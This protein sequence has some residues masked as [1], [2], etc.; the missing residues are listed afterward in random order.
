MASWKPTA[1][2]AHCRPRSARRPRVG[3][4]SDSFKLAKG[5]S[6]PPT[7]RQAT[8]P[9]SGVKIEAEGALLSATDGGPGDAPTRTRHRP[10]RGESPPS[11]PQR[12]A[13][14]QRWPPTSGG[15]PN[16]RDS[17]GFRLAVPP[18]SSTTSPPRPS[19]SSRWPRR[20]G[21]RRRRHDSRRRPP[22]VP[23]EI[24]PAAPTSRRPLHPPQTRS[25]NGSGRRSP[26]TSSTST[27][28]PPSS[29][30]TRA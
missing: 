21:D 14:P 25:P 28:I 26:A 19:R 8:L 15:S 4:L 23:P 20:A 30:R 16:R 6:A 17:T 27:P 13:R 2:V 22:S 9:T 11:R 1:F 24:S 7:S 18:S 3:V 29:T 12:A 10:R 5:A